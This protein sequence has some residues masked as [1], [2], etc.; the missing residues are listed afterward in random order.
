MFSTLFG[1]VNQKLFETECE[2]NKLVGVKT[3]GLNQQLSFQSQIVGLVLR[4]EDRGWL[5]R[6]P[7]ARI[8]ETFLEGAQSQN[9]FLILKIHVYANFALITMR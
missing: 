5:K 4:T 2:K 8:Q 3:V 1:K 9:F 7:Q 6:S